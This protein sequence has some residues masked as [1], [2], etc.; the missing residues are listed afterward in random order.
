MRYF[1]YIERREFITLVDG[2]AA[3]HGPGTADKREKGKAMNPQR[4]LVLAS[5][6]FAVPWTLGMIWWTG[7]N[8][9]NIIGFSISG[10]VAGVIWYFAMRWWMR[11]TKKRHVGSS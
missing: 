9:V 2:A 4:Q 6:I 7:V 10:V 11:W 3:A 1:S 5:V 8:T